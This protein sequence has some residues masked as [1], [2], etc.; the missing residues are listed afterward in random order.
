MI[1]KKFHIMAHVFPPVAQ[2][3]HPIR[4]IQ[5]CLKEH[6][7]PL[8]WYHPGDPVVPFAEKGAKNSESDFSNAL[9]FFHFSLQS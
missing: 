5:S 1:A 8:R 2:P 3:S 9:V 4:S 6:S 7:P